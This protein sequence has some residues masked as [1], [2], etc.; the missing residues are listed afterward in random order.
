LNSRLLFSKYLRERRRGTRVAIFHELHP[1]PI[2]LTARSW[3]SFLEHPDFASPLATVLVEK[4]LLISRQEEDQ[5]ELRMVQQRTNQNLNQT[6]ILYLLT[7]Q[8]CNLACSY[9]PVPSLA[10]QYGPINMTDT[11]A[12]AGVWLW[13]EHLAELYDE[14]RDYYV[15]FYG[16]EPLLNMP[17]I[18]NTLEYL[19]ELQ[20]GGLLP[21]SIRKMIATNGLLIDDKTI[22]LC[23]KHDVIVSVGIDGFD[24]KH[25]RARQAQ[26]PT[27]STD[28]VIEA[29]KILVSN[30]ITTCASVSIT[31]DN[32]EVVDSYYQTLVELGVEKFGFN[33][34]KGRALADYPGVDAETFYRQ[35][36][37]AMIRGFQNQ[38]RTD[39]EFQM[40]KKYSG[41]TGKN[42]FPVDCTCYGSQIVVQPNGQ[43]TNCPFYRNDMGDVTELVGTN[44]RIWQ[45]ETAQQWRQRLPIFNPAYDELD[46]KSLCGGGCA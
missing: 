34:L 13:R 24:A 3:D 43:V 26:Q 5:A 15:I 44:F 42:F 12:R 41:L 32:I 25:N 37:Q 39:F 35:A 20:Q 40:E 33:L 1:E 11:H 10:D 16:G 18:T 36:A 29:I 28:Q 21:G 30:N 22:G 17:I 23:Q 2:F 46:A 8:H 9:C 4:R 45:S 7:A 27:N 14:N 19:H 31:P 6:I 38:D